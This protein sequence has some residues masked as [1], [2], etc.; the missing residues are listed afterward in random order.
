MKNK[1]LIVVDP[2]N[3]FVRPD[4]ALSIKGAME[5]VPNINNLLLSDEFKLKIITQDFHPENHVS[6]A[7]THGAELFTTKQTLQ[8]GKFITQVMWPKHCVIGTYGVEIVNEIK[9]NAANIIFRKGYESD[10]ENYSFLEYVSEGEHHPT[11]EWIMFRDFYETEFHICGFA[12]D[13]CCK[14]TANS[15]K[16]LF[17]EFTT[18]ADTVKVFFHINAMAAVDPA[19]NDEVIEQLKKN[20]IIIV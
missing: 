4:G 5:V 13:Y 6:F 12:T 17:K 14:A 8:N 18:H 19:K 15:I 3:D 10:K 2:Q 20:G 9:K 11:F 1:I 7:D 16:N